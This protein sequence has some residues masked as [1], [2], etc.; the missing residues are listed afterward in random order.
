MDFHG[1]QRYVFSTLRNEANV[2]MYYYLIPFRL[3]TDSEMTL[4]DSEWL[5]CSLYVTVLRSAFEQF[6]S[7]LFTV[8]YVYAAARHVTRIE[9]REV[10]FSIVIR[11]LGLFGIG[12][13]RYIVETLTKLSLKL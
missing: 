7:Y 6:S 4:G 1:F 12:E 10:E 8:E 11:R 9:V 3:S 5:E 2:I 13:T